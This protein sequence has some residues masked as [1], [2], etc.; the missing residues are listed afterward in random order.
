MAE[1]Q[2]SRKALIKLVFTRILIIVVCFMLA[3]FLTAGTFDYWQA[4]VY[5]AILLIP[6][7]FAMRYFLK[8]NPDFLERRMRTGEKESAQKKIIRF[9]FIFF[10]LAFILP[11]F[12]KRWGWSNV[13]F[14]I[15][16]SA[17]LLVL[18]SY[19]FIVRVFKENIFASRIIEVDQKQKVISSGP[20]SIVRHPMYVGVALMYSLS[21]L[22]MGS[23]WALVPGLMIS[24]TLVARILNE[25]EVLSRDLPGYVEYKQKVKYRLLPGIW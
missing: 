23:W 3:F 20:Y 1:K 5:M 4:W 21:P 2:I 17:D 18:L 22:A 13:P 24:P 14:G 19:V 8:H 12:D 15:V 25:E 9:S 7:I 16:I 6:M 11:G 10:L